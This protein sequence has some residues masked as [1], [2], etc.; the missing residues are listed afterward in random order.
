MGDY[1][2]YSKR[3][4]HIMIH[5]RSG[6]GFLLQ[7]KEG[8]NGSSSVTDSDP[9]LSIIQTTRADEKTHIRGGPL[10]NRC[11]KRQAVISRLIKKGLSE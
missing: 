11:N 5:C 10:T 8:I 7:I 1:V 4:M 6:S 3:S 9:L 2:I